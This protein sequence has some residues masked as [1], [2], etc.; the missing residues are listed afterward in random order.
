MIR[1][2]ILSYYLINLFFASLLMS[3]VVSVLFIFSLL[4]KTN[5]QSKPRSVS[6]WVILTFR[7]VIVILPTLIATLSLLISPS[8]KIPPS[9]L[10]RVLLFRMSYLFLLSYHLLISFLQLQML[11]L[12]HF[13]FILAVL[14]LLQCH[15][16]NHLLCHS[17]LLLRFDNRM[18]IY[19]LSFGKVPALLLTHNLFIIIS[20]C[21]VYLY[22]IFALFS[23]CLLSLPLKALV[24]LSLIRAE[25]RQW[26]RK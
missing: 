7:R 14:V 18:M 24:R 9:P 11:C 25:N 6:S 5:S 13:R 16:L 15:L 20:T 19:L 23:S 17:H 12:D 3:L 26:L 2:L 22:P 8:L 21:I 10:Q 1:S 4:G